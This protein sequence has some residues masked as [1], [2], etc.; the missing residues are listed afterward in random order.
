MGWDLDSTILSSCLILAGEQRPN[1]HHDSRIVSTSSF[2]HQRIRFP[3]PP[4]RLLPTKL[5]HVRFPTHHRRVLSCSFFPSHLEIHLPIILSLYLRVKKRWSVVSVFQTA[6]V[7]T[8][9]SCFETALGARLACQKCASSYAA[10]LDMHGNGRPAAP[11]SGTERNGMTH[12]KQLFAVQSTTTSTCEAS[13]TRRRTPLSKSIVDFEEGSWR[14]GS[15]KQRRT[16]T[17]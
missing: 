14:N 15:R 3:A 4:P 2:F 16:T 17:R 9:S 7:S 6:L 10:D 13:A 12:W 1:S 5:T 8:T 11:E